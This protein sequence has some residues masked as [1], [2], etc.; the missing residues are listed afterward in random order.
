MATV[1]LKNVSKTYLVPFFGGKYCLVEEEAAFDGI[2]YVLPSSKMLRRTPP[3]EHYETLMKLLGLDGEIITS[4]TYGDSQE[5]ALYILVNVR[6]VGKGD[7][8]TQWFTPEEIASY[9]P[10]NN[11][12][13]GV[14]GT[15]INDLRLI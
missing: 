11:I 3:S 15:M 9:D 7:V 13:P 1:D 12:H 2:E 6:S 8:R 5:V 10:K 4:H 14:T